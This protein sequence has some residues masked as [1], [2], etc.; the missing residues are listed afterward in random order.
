MSG[1]SSS[2]PFRGALVKKNA[3]QTGANYTTA[4]AIA[5]NAETYDTDNFHDTVTNNSRLTIPS[6]LGITKVRLAASVRISGISPPDVA[7]LDLRK[8]G[9]G[10]FDGSM[11]DHR[12]CTTVSTT[13][14]SWTS[15][16][17]D[18]TDGDYFE[19]FLTIVTDTTVDITAVVS[20]F[21]IEVVA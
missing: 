1:F 13:H 12:D 10:V 8:N 3:D 9:S 11:R 21:G 5:W 20:S 18:V 4:T 16:V 7:L 19:A 17:V 2:R 6:G 15:P 14:L